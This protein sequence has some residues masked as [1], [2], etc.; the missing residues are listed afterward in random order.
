MGVFNGGRE[1]CSGMSLHGSATS[2]VLES[3]HG[4]GGE[5]CPL[6]PNSS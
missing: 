6:Q 1:K 2:A 4:G 3:G 5:P